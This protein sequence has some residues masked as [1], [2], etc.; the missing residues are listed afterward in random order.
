MC[1]MKNHP[2]MYNRAREMVRSTGINPEMPGYEM[3]IK[4]IVTYK[5]D[6]P[7]NIY[8]NIAKETSVIP[9][10][11]DLEKNQHP[12]KQ[13]MTESMKSIGSKQNDVM[14]FIKKLADEC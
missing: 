4:A 14:V 7:E 6:G 12:V 10:Q 3:L 9:A 11:K 2:Q 13:M 8:A 5:V 1:K